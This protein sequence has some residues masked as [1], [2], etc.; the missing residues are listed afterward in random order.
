[1]DSHDL[2]AAVPANFN[3][4]SYSGQWTGRQIYFG[5]GAGRYPTAY[6]VVQ[7]CL[8]V[9]A[10]KRDFYTSAMVAAPVDK[11]SVAHPYYVRTACPDTWLESV[12]ADRWESGV[13]T[14]AVTV[15][16]MHA[17]AGEQLKKDPTCFIAG[18]R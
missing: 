13:I 9:L 6:N 18:I 1:M 3:L 8:D 11:E 4:I 2:E 15:G 10:G 5:Q 14:S 7:D 12:T 17:W 16:Q